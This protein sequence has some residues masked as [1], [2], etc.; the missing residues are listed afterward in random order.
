[1]Q[2]TCEQCDKPYQT[3]HKKS[4]FCSHACANTRPNTG[5]WPK[6]KDDELKGRVSCLRCGA[7]LA[8]TQRLNGRTYCGNEC[9]ILHKRSLINV[10]AETCLG[11]DK[12][13][14]WTE[15]SIGKKYCSTSCYDDCRYPA[16]HVNT[17][18]GYA[19]ITVSRG[20]KPQLQ[21][22]YVMEQH[23]GR[24][25]V[26]GENVH[27]VNGVKDDNRIENLE[28]WNTSQP[29]GQRATDKVSWAKEILELY[30]ELE[31]EGKI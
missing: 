26:E 29:C 7:P 12:P 17:R 23:L 11:C 30:K 22:R 10:V 9:S 24:S 5:R 18:T 20:K 15:K 31:D 16:I 28:L 21:H 1:M 25:L 27:H 14:S 4:K 19:T 3:K 8:R 6:I 13:F 2:K